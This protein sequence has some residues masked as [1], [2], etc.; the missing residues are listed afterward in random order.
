[1]KRKIKKIENKSWKYTINGAKIIFGFFWYSNYKVAQ[2]FVK[3]LPSSTI[4]KLCKYYY[5]VAQVLHFC[6]NDKLKINI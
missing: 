3:K 2:S 5:K 6:I 4:T 1:M